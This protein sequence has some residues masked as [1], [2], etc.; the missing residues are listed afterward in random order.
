MQMTRIALPVL[1]VGFRVVLELQVQQL[2]RLRISHIMD[3]GAQALS[4]RF[5]V[6]PFLHTLELRVA[7]VVE[8]FLPFAL[9]GRVEN[10]LIHQALWRSTKLVCCLR[11]ITLELR[12]SVSWHLLIL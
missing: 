8:E 3:F 9:L 5:A 11:G 7:K 6:T 12:Q 4:R 1:L 2:P 10:H